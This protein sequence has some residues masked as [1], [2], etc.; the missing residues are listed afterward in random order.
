MHWQDYVLAIGQIIFFF[1]LIPALRYAHKPPLSTSIIN[2]VVLFIFATIYI[3]LALWFAA[4]TALMT[5]SMWFA[6]AI[7]AFRKKT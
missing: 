7:Q 3:T 5:G 1:A 4:I 6:L 2:G